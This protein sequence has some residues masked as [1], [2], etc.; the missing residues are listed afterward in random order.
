MEAKVAKIYFDKPRRKGVWLKERDIDLLRM[1]YIHGVLTKLQMY[2]YGTLVHQEKEDSMKRKFRRWRDKDILIYKKYGPKASKKLYFELGAKGYEVLLNQ[3]VINEIPVPKEIKFPKNKDHFIGLR[4][5]VVKI[6]AESRKA[7]K[8]IRSFTPYEYDYKR[9][10]KEE[11]AFLRPDW[12]LKTEDELF[13]IE[14]DTGSEGHQKVKA[15]VESYVELAKLNPLEN[16]HVFISVIDNVDEV[17]TY[18]DDGYGLNRSGR[19]LNLKKVILDA[20]AQIHSNL[21]FTVAQISRTHLIAKKWVLGDYGYSKEE[22]E[23]EINR[24]VSAMNQNATFN[25]T[26]D[27]FMDAS[28]FYLP[29][30][31]ESLYGDSHIQL[32]SVTD[33]EDKVMIVKL[34]KEGDVACMDE[35]GYLNQLKRDGRFKTKVD[36]IVAI[37]QTNDEMEKDSLD[38]YENVIFTNKELLVNRAESPFRQNSK[39]WKVTIL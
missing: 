1:L 28:D 16:H 30:V 27:T 20:N 22:A 10:E 8:H 7:K 39:D 4:D 36:F 11:N 5:V 14:L 31:K 19:V 6:L 2:H 3:G 17:F 26:F 23:K 29:E 35:L 38:K 34:M 25:Y 12:I 24:L 15:K 37:Y 33:E 13:N 9:D 18:I 21:K 32:K